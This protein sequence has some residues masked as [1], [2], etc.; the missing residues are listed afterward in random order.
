MDF[1]HVYVI[2]STDHDF[3]YIGMTNN[4]SR[5]LKEHNNG[6]ENSTKAYAPFNLIFYEGYR[7]KSDAKR[8]EEYLKTTKGKRVL[9]RVLRDYFDND[10]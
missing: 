6:E 3:L 7:N 10:L 1:Y 9:C 8:R 2:D 4:L 5:C